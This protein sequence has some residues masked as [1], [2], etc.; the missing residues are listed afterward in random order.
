MAESL[1]RLVAGSRPG[2]PLPFPQTAD[3][4][5]LKGAGRS[6]L[7]R[8]ML[9]A[10]AQAAAAHHARSPLP[11][12]ISALRPPCR[13]P[14]KAVQASGAQPPRKF[15]RRL[16]WRS[17]GLGVGCNAAPFIRHVAT[18]CSSRSADLWGGIRPPPIKQLRRS[19]PPA[20]RMP[21]YLD[22]FS[23][24]R[25]L[26]APMVIL[27][28]FLAGTPALAEGRCPPGSYPIGGQGVGGCAPIA[29]GGAGPDAGPKATGRWHKTWGG[30]AQA[31][32][33]GDIGVALGQTSK[34]AAVSESLARC[35]EHG[36]KDCEVDLTFKNQC[37][38]VAASSAPKLTVSGR[39]A[40][41]ERAI[42]VAI[43]ACESKAGS[44]CR[45]AYSG[46][47]EPKFEA[48]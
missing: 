48:F 22:N 35:A 32:S 2:A 9:R 28:G 6:K 14:V 41:T 8:R 13:P 40:S 18:R 15:P 25:T 34:S 30:I 7:R 37:V 12:K 46:C 4:V 11:S 1:D 16:R 43:D 29:A 45:V 10:F 3:R 26:V 24:I 39:A 38:A 33:T 17:A 20:P 21:A 31:R 27:L 23:T 36:A 5:P 19:S 42:I 44:K 47:T